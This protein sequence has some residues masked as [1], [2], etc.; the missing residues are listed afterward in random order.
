M[1]WN[2]ILSSKKEATKKIKKNR[3]ESRWKRGHRVTKSG[4]IQIQTQ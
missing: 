2:K 4:E 3:Q 1:K